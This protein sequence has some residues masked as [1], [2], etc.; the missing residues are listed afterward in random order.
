[1]IVAVAL[2]TAGA[3]AVREFIKPA[4]V[5]LPPILK[6]IMGWD[7]RLLARAAVPEYPCLIDEKH[8]TG[9][10]FGFINVPMAT[11]IDEEG[12]IV[13]PAEPAGM[14]DGMRSMDPATFKIPEHV[15]AAGK[16]LRTSYIDAIRDWVNKGAKS[17]YA[18]SREEILRRGEGPDA[19]DAL[20]A[21]NFRLGQYLF[22]EGHREDAAPYFAKARELHPESWSYKRQTWELEQAGKAAG[23]EFFAA[24]QALGDKYYY[25][26]VKLKASS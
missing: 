9:E 26:P 11:W 16:A 17:E 20:A 3:S 1:V 2:D 12:H 6:D 23:P 7:D 4:S 5:E 13:R 14:S 19:T 8:I 15:V 25:A 18:L 22:A 24:V 21:A 10:L